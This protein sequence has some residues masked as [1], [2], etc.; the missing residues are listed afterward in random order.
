M[1][2]HPSKVETHIHSSERALFLVPLDRTGR[3]G[4]NGNI[5]DFGSVLPRGLGSDGMRRRITISNRHLQGMSA[6]MS[7]PGLAT[8]YLN[9]HQDDVGP[10]VSRREFL[11]QII[12]HLLSIPHGV[13]GKVQFF[14][15]LQGDLLIDMAA[16][17]CQVL[18]WSIGGYR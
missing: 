9:I 10:R 12:Q 7:P 4:Y 11:R 6:I 2:T 5:S 15:R 3:H 8:T 18:F 13:D 14:Y 1:S 16:S 17:T